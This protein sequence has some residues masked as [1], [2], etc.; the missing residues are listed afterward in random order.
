VQGGADPFGRPGQFPP[1]PP[2]ME[3]VEVPSA[4]HTFGTGL[5]GPNVT[6]I[7]RVVAAV[8]EWIDRQLA[9]SRA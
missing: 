9:P 6:S 5:G 7:T 3:L 8:T 4:S 2:G 1:L